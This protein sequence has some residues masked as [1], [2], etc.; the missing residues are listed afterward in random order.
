MKESTVGAMAEYDPRIQA[1]PER[2][3]LDA[4]GSAKRATV[5]TILDPQELNPTSELCAGTGVYILKDETFV[6]CHAGC[7][8]ILFL[9]LFIRLSKSTCELNTSVERSLAFRLGSRTRQLEL[10]SFTT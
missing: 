3:G 5:C 9:T 8:L 2:K 6:E 1:F 10:A 7:L 4:G